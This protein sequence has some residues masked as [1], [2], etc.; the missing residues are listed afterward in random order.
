[1][2]ELKNV[3]KYYKSRF[4]RT[5]ILKNVNFTV[6]E[7][8][9]VSIMGPS[10]AGKSTLLNIIGMLDEPSEGEYYFMGNPVHKMTEKI[11][12]YVIGIISVLY[13]RLTI[14]WKT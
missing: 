10:G 3:D 11:R 12:I 14:C 6:K 7:G 9:F 5:F 1:M 4:Q 8:E 13:S 2:I